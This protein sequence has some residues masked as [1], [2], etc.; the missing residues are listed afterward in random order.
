MNKLADKAETKKAL[1]H[2]E[3]KINQLYLLV[4]KESESHDHEEDGIVVKRPL[5]WSCLGCDKQ[6]DKYSGKLGDYKAWKIMPPKE[7]SPDRMG[8]VKKFII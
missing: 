3:N 8:K 4:S 6:L 2:L 1:K 7:T 5:L